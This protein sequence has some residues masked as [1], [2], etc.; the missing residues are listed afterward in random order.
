MQ[1]QNTTEA[2]KLPT[3]LPDTSESEDDKVVM[4]KIRSIVKRGNNAEIKQRKDGSLAVMEV[5]KNIV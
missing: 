5:K 2:K 3:I 4:K 1:Y